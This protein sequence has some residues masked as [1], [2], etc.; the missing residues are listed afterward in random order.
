MLLTTTE[1][2][3]TTCSGATCAELADAGLYSPARPMASRNLVNL[4]NYFRQWRDVRVRGGENLTSSTLL[5][6][7]RANKFAFRSASATPVNF[8]QSCAWRGRGRSKGSVNLHSLFSLPL[9]RQKSS[10][11]SKLFPPVAGCPGA[12]RGPVVL[13]EKKT[14]TIIHGHLR[15]FTFKETR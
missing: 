6:L 3:R 14:F 5:H 10:K 13:K 7:G 9:M 15:Q 11:S 1:T 4:V 12:G 8:C 2:T